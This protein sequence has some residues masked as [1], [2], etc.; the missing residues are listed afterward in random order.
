MLTNAEKTLQALLKEQRAKVEEIKKKTNFY[1]T[2]ELLA[3]YDASAP[4]SPQQ[5][6]QRPSGPQTPQ[7]GAHESRSAPFCNRRSYFASPPR[8]HRQRQQHHRHRKQR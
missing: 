4:S 6:Q 8:L 5:Q 2:R 7:R 1:S 3:R